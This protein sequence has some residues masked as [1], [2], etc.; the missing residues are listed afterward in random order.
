MTYLT[1]SKAADFRVGDL[2]RDTS[3]GEILLV[4]RVGSGLF[5]ESVLCWSVIGLRKHW[6]DKYNIHYLEVLSE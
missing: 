6:Y 4:V 3:D 2:V 1:D 5:M